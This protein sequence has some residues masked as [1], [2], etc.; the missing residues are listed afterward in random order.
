AEEGDLRAVEELLDHDTAVGLGEA[1]Q[2]VR[3]GL[4]VVLGDD[5]ALAGGQPVVLDDVG[6]AGGCERGDNVVLAA[7]HVRQ[8][9]RHASG[10]HDLLGEGLAALERGGCCA[11]PEAPDAASSDRVRDPGY[12]WCLWADDDQVG[13]DVLGK[14]RHPGGVGDRTPV[15]A[16]TG[17]QVDAG[18]AGSRQDRVDG[19]VGGEGAHDGVLACA[20]T[21]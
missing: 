14:L 8:G 20:G 18:V 11:R 21:Y 13:G 16:A 15:R 9:G 17:H 4:G 1:G 10:G 3:D 2:G 19:R 6:S 5:D 12:Q 7:A